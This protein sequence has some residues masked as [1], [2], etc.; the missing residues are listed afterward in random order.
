MKQSLLAFA[1]IISTFTSCKTN[2]K[3]ELEERS[4]EGEVFFAKG[5]YDAKDIGI[6]TSAFADTSIQMIRTNTF[7]ANRE[8]RYKVNVY[9][10]NTIDT[11]VI[12][13]AIDAAA[14]GDT[15][16]VYNVKSY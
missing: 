14:I 11:Q 12:Q 8:S 1:I 3:P 10:L 9:L 4:F 15:N 2:N 13:S 6:V 16:K 5:V 7:E